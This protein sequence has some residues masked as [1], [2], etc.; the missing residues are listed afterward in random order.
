MGTLTGGKRGHA[1][2]RSLVA[3]HSLDLRGDGRQ[4][5]AVK[6][7]LN[8]MK[9]ILDPAGPAAPAE[10]NADVLLRMAEDGDNLTKSRDIDFHHLFTSM[11]DAQA[12][13]DAVR[14]QGYAKVDH[15]FWQEKNAWLTVVH[16]RMVPVLDEITATELALA[17]TAAVYEGKP[18]GWG[19][20]EVI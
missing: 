18:D 10:E 4:V 15:D 19:C 13:L 6:E 2:P 16:V 5:G 9:R 3:L 12:F 17:E 7:H 14:G 8:W 20:M 1:R 11:A